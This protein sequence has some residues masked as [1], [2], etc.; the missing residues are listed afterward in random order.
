MLFGLSRCPLG[1]VFSAQWPR[2]ARWPTSRRSPVGRR[3]GRSWSLRKQAM[4]KQCSEGNPWK[5][6]R[7]SIENPWIF[8]DFQWIFNG[9]QAVSCRFTASKAI[10]SHGIGSA[11]SVV[12]AEP[13]M[14][15]DLAPK[16]QENP[17]NTHKNPLK[18]LE[19]HQKTAKIT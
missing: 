14:E 10:K 12:M 1:M 4:F 6:D 9:F 13:M 17:S 8:S 19:N 15:P 3:R 16:L 5:I 2:R 11:P 7:K 18:Q